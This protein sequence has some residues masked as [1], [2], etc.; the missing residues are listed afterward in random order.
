MDMVWILVVEFIKT[1]IKIS[2]LFI[3][4]MLIAWQLERDRKEIEDDE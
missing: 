1:A 4:G 3:T 2:P